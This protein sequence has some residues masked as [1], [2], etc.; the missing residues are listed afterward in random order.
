MRRAVSHGERLPMDINKW[1]F[2]PFSN[3]PSGGSGKQESLLLL[4]HSSK[5]V[6]KYV[7]NI[8]PVLGSASGFFSFDKNIDKSILLTVSVFYSKVYRENS[9]ALPLQK[10]PIMLNVCHSL[11][12][13]KFLGIC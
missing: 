5:T 8:F 10:V 12:I 4:R 7:G 2:F 6:K 1:I 3:Q 13:Y 9:C 11:R